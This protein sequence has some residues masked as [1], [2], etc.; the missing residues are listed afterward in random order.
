MVDK[1]DAVGL[2]VDDFGVTLDCVFDCVV[3]CVFDC[4]LNDIF[5][6]E[7]VGVVVISNNI[8]LSCAP[9]AIICLDLL[10]ISFILFIRDPPTSAAIPAPSLVPPTCVGYIGWHNLQ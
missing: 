1:F 6:E 3:D 5:D 10:F 4:V 7:L 8:F 2:T 9:P